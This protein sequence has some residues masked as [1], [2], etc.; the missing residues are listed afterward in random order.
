MLGHVP[1]DGGNLFLVHEDFQITGLAEVNLG[2]KEGGTLD[3]AVLCR[4]QIGQR[5]CEQSSA[6]AVAERIDRPLASGLLD[7]VQRLQDALAHVVL[8]GLAGEFFVGINPGDY[9]N[10]L[11]LVH[12]PSD[13]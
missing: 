13:E 3:S 9:E 5:S 6:D 8:E 10:R 11:T 1:L 7:C 2:G 4:C 12:R